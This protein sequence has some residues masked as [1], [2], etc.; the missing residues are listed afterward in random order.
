LEFFRLEKREVQGDLTAAFQYLKGTY[1]KD[2]EELFTRMCHDRTRRNGFK[3][4][5]GRVR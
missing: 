4:K 5:K 1:N 3:L 2:G